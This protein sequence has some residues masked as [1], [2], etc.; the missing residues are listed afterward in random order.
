M[1]RRAG[2]ALATLT[3]LAIWAALIALAWRAL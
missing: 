1:T 3:S 2:L